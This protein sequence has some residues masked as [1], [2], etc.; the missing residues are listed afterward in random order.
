[1]KNALPSPKTSFINENTLD[2]IL[3]SPLYIPRCHEP[4]MMSKVPKPEPSMTLPRCQK[5]NPKTYIISYY[6]IIIITIEV[7]GF[8]AQRSRDRIVSIDA[9]GGHKRHENRYGACP[10]KAEWT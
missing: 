4:T 8:V 7:R 9:A 10:P 2:T 1:M 3:P 5:Q 6:I